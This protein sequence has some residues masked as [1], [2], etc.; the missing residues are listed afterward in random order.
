MLKDSSQNS[1]SFHAELYNLI[2][3]DHILEKYSLLFTVRAILDYSLTLR[4]PSPFLFLGA[5][6]LRK[7]RTSNV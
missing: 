4:L 7:Y 5:P 3:D 2:P 1:L 6:R